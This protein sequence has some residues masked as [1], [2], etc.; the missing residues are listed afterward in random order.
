MCLNYKTSP[1]MSLHCPWWPLLSRYFELFGSAKG[2]KDCKSQEIH[3]V[4]HAVD[5]PSFW[6]KGLQVPVSKSKRSLGCVRW[7]PSFTLHD[8]LSGPVMCWFS[9]QALFLKQFPK[10]CSKVQHVPES[11]SL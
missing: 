9:I 2:K 7:L 4:D 10:L 1:F 5:G 8:T 6:G 3:A 11:G